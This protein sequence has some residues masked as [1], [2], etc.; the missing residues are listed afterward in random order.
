V[1]LKNLGDLRFAAG[2]E[3]AAMAFY[4][5]A[6]E[7]DPFCRGLVSVLKMK[8]KETT[9]TITL[10]RADETNA[11]T[12]RREMPRIPF[13][14]ETIGD[15]YLAQGHP[16]LAAEVFRTLGESGGPRVLEKLQ[17][18]EKKARERET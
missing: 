8:Q 10:R 6:M 7:I 15:I 3:L 12:S 1:A 4:Q 14:T 16:R 2:D 18:A 13:F 5:R 17:R 9:R 11:D